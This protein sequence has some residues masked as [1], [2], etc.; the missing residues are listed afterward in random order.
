MKTNGK[1][2]LKTFV[3]GLLV[4]FFATQGLYATGTSQT[5]Q[6]GGNTGGGPV[7]L[8]VLVTNS[9]GNDPSKVRLTKLLEEGTNTVL[10]FIEAGTGNNYLQKL[11]VVMA[12]GDYPDIFAVTNNS[13][14][15]SYAQS[16][17]L[18]PLNKYWDKY[19]NIKNGRSEEIWKVMTHPDG[20]VYV[21]PRNGRLG[22]QVVKHVNWMLLFREDYLEKANMPVPRTLDDYWKFCEFIRDQDPDGNGKRDTFAIIGYNS[23]ASSFEHVFSAFGVQY[24]YWMARSGKVVQG[25]VQPEMK[26][27]LKYVNRMYAAGFVDPEWVTDSQQRFID[28]YQHGLLSAGMHWGHNLDTKNFQGFYEAL[29]RNTNGVAKYT[30]GDQW[31][32]YGSYKPFGYRMNSP[33]GQSRT[34]IYSGTKQLD[35]ALRVVDWECRPESMRAY[36]YGIEGETFRVGTDGVIDFFGTM[37]QQKEIGISSY[38]ASIVLNPDHQHASKYYQ[39]CIL[40]QNDLLAP[41][42]L[43]DIYLVPEIAEYGSQLDTF[44]DEQFV[45]FIIGEQSI[46]Q[47]WDAFVAEYARRGGTQVGDALTVTYQKA[48]GR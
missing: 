6:S 16:G 41:T 43:A 22:S 14:E 24:N 17:A 47:N 11:N 18:L 25:A 27:A 12:S 13:I 40:R 29:Q 26:E 44:V 5:S 38:H 42:N 35:A 45:R 34:A 30:F 33:R 28:K 3:I 19:T 7:H 15:L 10:E 37:D 20:N 23:Q 46:D 1:W 4:I 21:V 36:S 2:F 9:L 32:T 31:L 8:K 39:S 48:G